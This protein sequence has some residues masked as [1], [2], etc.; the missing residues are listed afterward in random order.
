MKYWLYRI[1][2]EEYEELDSHEQIEIDYMPEET[3]K[4][5][6]FIIH[7]SEI[8]IILGAYRI[9]DEKLIAKELST[10]KPKLKEF[11]EKLSFIDFVNDR[12]YKIFA[13]RL[14]EITKEDYEMLKEK[15]S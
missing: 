13:K 15:L 7:I 1:K 5:D 12:T 10:K 8:G 3:D 11:Y 4:E 9:N 14:K 2:K 6:K